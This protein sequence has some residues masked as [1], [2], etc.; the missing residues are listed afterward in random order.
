MHV[1]ALLTILKN[2]QLIHLPIFRL[3]ILPTLAS[4]Y[5]VGVLVQF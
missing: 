1:S 2:A 3:L 5:T 4:V